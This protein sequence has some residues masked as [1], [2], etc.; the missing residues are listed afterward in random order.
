MDSGAPRRSG[1]SPSAPLLWVPFSRAGRKSP[2]SLPE[3]RPR[4]RTDDR[5]GNVFRAEKDPKLPARPRSVREALLPPDV[6]GGPGDEDFRPTREPATSS[7]RPW[8]P[9]TPFCQDEPLPPSPTPELKARSW[10]TS[11]SDQLSARS[12]RGPARRA[13]WGRSTRLGCDGCRPGC[14]PGCGAVPLFTDQLAKDEG[15]NWQDSLKYKLQKV[16]LL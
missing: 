1:P 13:A 5:S 7:S 3:R 8:D 10:G 16:S 15:G 12:A 2:V 11:G 14:R 9:R 6:S 4:H